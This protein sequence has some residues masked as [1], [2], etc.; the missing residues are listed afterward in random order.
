[1]VNKDNLRPLYS[2][3]QGLLSQAPKA[4]WLGK[5]EHLKVPKLILDHYNECVNN[6]INFTQDDHY[7]RF[8]VED[9]IPSIYRT[10]LSGLILR[11]YGKYFSDEQA[12]FSGTPSTVISQ[13]QQQSQMFQ[14]ELQQQVKN[15]IDEQLRKLEPEDTKRGFLEKVKGFLKSVRSGPELITLILETATEYGVTLDALKGLFN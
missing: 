6:L 5:V 9:D 3:L 8:F 1:M 14:V 7:A 13:S 15:K 2:E 4:E 12:P 11:L 10:K